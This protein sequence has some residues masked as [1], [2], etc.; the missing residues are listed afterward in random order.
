MSRDQY[1]VCVR[2]DGELKKS[3]RISFGKIDELLEI[4]GEVA[5]SKQH[6]VFVDGYALNVPNHSDV[7]Q[8]CYFWLE[9]DREK[10]RLA[11]VCSMSS[12]YKVKP[13]EDMQMNVEEFF[14]YSWKVQ[15][16][17][18]AVQ[19][20]DFFSYVKNLLDTDLSFSSSAMPEEMVNISPNVKKGLDSK[21]FK[22]SPATPEELVLSKHYFAGSSARWM[23]NF[24]TKKVIEFTKN[25]VKEVDDIMLYIKGT[26]GQQSNN[27]VNR[28]LSTFLDSDGEKISIVSRFAGVELAIKAGPELISQLSQVTK[29]DGNPSMD[30]WLLEMWFFA[31]LRSGGV[32]LLDK[33]GTVQQTWPQY[34]V[35]NLDMTSFPSL[36]KND[37]VWFKPNKWNQGGFDAIYMNKSIGLVRFVQITGGD[38]HSFKIE[39]FYS[40]LFA[41]SQSPQS[42][43]ITCLE[44]FFVV[45]LKKS[46][47]FTLAEPSG[48]GLLQTF[49]WEYGKERNKVN[50]IFIN[51]WSES[52]LHK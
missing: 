7:Q 26:V 25:S 6:I 48:V 5:D 39:Y 24:S 8:A 22:N 20:P 52:A 29:L 36:P 1:P 17:L 34:S 23:F 30:G 38:T 42:F 33:N 31:S 9:T 35:R 32:K 21:L 51:K 15:E 41:L 28:L 18:D 27:V 40:F 49:G 47:T 4:L 3:R 13:H 12:R 50:I 45:D 11:I 2:L 37:G 43:E 46:E 14:V 16:Y 19:N 44:I 10:R